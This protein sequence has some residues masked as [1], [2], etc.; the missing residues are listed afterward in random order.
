M[1]ETPYYLIHKDMLDEGMEKLKKALAD[2]WPNA[3]I[4]YSFK[5]N[6]LPWVLQ[7]ME[8]QG[9]RAEVVSQDE[10]ELAEYMGYERIIYNGPVKGKE[11]FLRACA[12]G[13]IVNLDAKRELG[14][15]REACASGQTVQVGTRVNFDLE[16]LCPGEASGGEE[17]GRFGFSYENG[18][19]AR[20]LE[21]LSG[22]PGATVAGIHLHCS[23]RTRS[24]AIYRAIAQTACRLR[25]EYDL[26]LSYI[27]VGGGYFGGLANKPQY[28][29]YLREMSEI[30]REEYDPAETMLIVEPGTSLICPPVEYVTTV[31]DAKETNRNHFVVTDGSRIHVD[32]LMTKKSYFHHIEYTDGEEGRERLKKQ[33]V[34]GFT[35]MENDRLFE[36]ADGSALCEGDRIVYEKVGAYTMCLSPLF[37]SWFPAVW[38]EENGALRLVR[39]KWSAREYA[40]GSL[41]KE[42]EV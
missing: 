6:A 23:S 13:Q 29:D 19:F 25:R 20:A 5:T 16:A 15:L 32:P 3:A 8:E 28:A 41:W 12:T 34:S 9:C 10:Y 24:L 4:G 21:A 11:S 31:T 27:D 42:K 36:I 37:I 2:Y 14:W 17:G 18:D 22:I 39:E 33:V 7:Y 38:L 40:Q 35:C 1:M 26:K 30:L